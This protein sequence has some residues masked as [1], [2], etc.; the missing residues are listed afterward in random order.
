MDM[1]TCK[2]CILDSNTPGISIDPDTGWCQFCTDFTPPGEDERRR[3]ADILNNFFSL[4]HRGGEYDVIVALSGGID[5][6]YALYH[7]KEQYY[8]LNILAVQFDNGFLSETALKNA[9][10]FCDLTDSTYYR[11][12]VDQQELNNTFVRAASSRNVY[13]ESAMHRAS[14]ICNTCIGI[15]KQKI[16]EL[17]MKTQAP[18]VVFAFS[19]GQTDAPF[20]VLTGSLL[21]W[22][23]HLFDASLTTMGVT[24]RKPYLLDEGL[25]GDGSSQPEVV[26]IHPFLV[27]EYHKPDFKK[28]CR[29]L[30]WIEPDLMDS[31]SSNCLLNTYAIKNHLEKYNIHPYASDL[32]S[33]VRQGYMKREEALRIL[34]KPLPEEL[35]ERVE[36]RLYDKEEW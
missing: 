2:R 33:L 15:L 1:T 4:P 30:G 26:L 19:P 23:R 21:A 32:A 11:L 28:R 34:H 27:W 20:I 5:S 18:A 29:A 31:N 9:R 14:D 10:M 24:N 16:I 17:A 13:S 8:H 25:I 12:A 3:N 36:K 6:S 7:L 22:M 35:I